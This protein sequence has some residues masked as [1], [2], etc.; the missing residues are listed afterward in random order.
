MYEVSE[1]IESK[2]EKISS[3]LG[4]VGQFIMSFI[5]TVVVALVISVVLYLFIMTPH[6]VFGNSM[7]PTYQNGEYLMANKIQYKLFGDPERGDVIIF[8]YS[9]TQDFIMSFFHSFLHDVKVSGWT[10]HTCS[11]WVLQIFHH[12]VEFVRCDIDAVMIGLSIHSNS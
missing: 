3:T 1:G 5:E 9:D 8:K 6:E 2:N 11:R 12:A 7:H 4:S 10:W